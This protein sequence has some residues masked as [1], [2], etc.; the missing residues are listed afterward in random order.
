[1]SNVRI[2][3]NAAGVRELLKSEAIAQACKEQAVRVKE[4]VGKG[5]EVQSRKYPERTGYAVSA[6]SREALRSTLQD[7]VLLKAL[8]K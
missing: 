3:L 1:M 7:N 8:G 5:F 4:T 6:E 2:E